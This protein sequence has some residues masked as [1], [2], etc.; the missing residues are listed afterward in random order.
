MPLITYLCLC[1]LISRFFISFRLDRTNNPGTTSGMNNHL[2]REHQ[3]TKDSNH[4]QILA[5]KGLKQKADSS[6]L[7]FCSNTQAEIAVPVF[8]SI[9][10]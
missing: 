3:L 4:E 2:K 6:A 5:G 10:F 1:L 9:F 8:N 7:F